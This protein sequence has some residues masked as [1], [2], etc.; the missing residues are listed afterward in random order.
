ME[1]I[2]K[3]I[4]REG[5][6]AWLYIA[7]ALFF[8]TLFIFV[9][10]FQLFLN[11]FYYMDGMGTKEFIGL[12]NYRDILTD[13][14]F[15]QTVKN[16]FIFIFVSVPLGMV[17]SLV[18]ALLILKEIRGQGVFRTIFF[19]PVVTSLVA[20]GLMWVWILNYDFGI[21]NQFIQRLGFD[22]IPWLVSSKYAM[23]S[24]I[25]MT[26]W[27]DAGYNMILFL[28]G[29]NGISSVYYEAS[30]IDG[31]TK[32]QQFKHIT[33]P[34]LMPTTVFIFIVRMIFS[35]RTFEQIYAMTKGGPVGSTRVFVYYIYET[36]FQF[37]ELGKGSAAAILLL[38]IV[39]SL[40]GIQAFISRKSENDF[41]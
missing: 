21:F 26:I 38:I 15:W 22:K 28:A 3:F 33:W 35:F 36:S 10:T 7:P 1:K 37:F 8:L 31:A 12:E 24:V 29:L 23:P 4:D 18:L 40:V 41:A 34:M 11:S 25:L 13:P 2:K 30:S 39:L 32:W 5:V 19:A 17:V 16:S 20:A 27:K 6:S 14:D 9:P